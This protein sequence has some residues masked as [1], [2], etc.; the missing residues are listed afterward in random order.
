MGVGMANFISEVPIEEA[1]RGVASVIE[2][3]DVRVRF[4]RR[5]LRAMRED[6]RN[7][8]RL[9]R[10]AAFDGAPAWALEAL[11]TGKPVHAF[12]LHPECRRV[13]SAQAAGLQ[14][15]V[16]AQRAFGAVKTEKQRA[17]VIM[18]RELTGFHHTMS[19]QTLATKIAAALRMRA[20]VDAE[21]AAQTRLCAPQRI[22][23]S[24]REAWV[25]ICT[26]QELD[27]AGAALRNCLRGAA[28]GGNPIGEQ[29]AKGLAAMWRLDR[30]G[31]PVA[32]AKILTNGVLSEIQ[33]PLNRPVDLRGPAIAVLLEAAVT[34]VNLHVF[35][36]SVAVPR[37]RVRQLLD[38]IAECPAA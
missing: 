4:E 7:A 2:D 33:G 24:D 13:L 22:P 27:D 25:R 9:R 16:L 12:A 32:A 11:A 1:A 3:R 23:V 34:Q 5:A 17:L 35:N 26:L 14:S 19:S 18:A 8:R 28:R 37:E 10:M 31:V 36:R 29:M 15:M 30:D 20:V 6:P 38:V 21:C